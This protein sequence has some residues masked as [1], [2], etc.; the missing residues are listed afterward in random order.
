MSQKILSLLIFTLLCISQYSFADNVIHEAISVVLDDV[1]DAAD[2]ADYERYF[3][4]YAENS[5]FFGTDINERWPLDVFKKYTKARFD[6]GNGWTYKATSRNIFLSNDEQTAW[7][8]EILH[9]EK[10]G[11]SRATGVLVL[12]DGQ[13]KLAQYHLTI[14]IPNELA[15]DFVDQILEFEKKK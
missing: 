4:H 5:V 7:F 10:Y 8:D 9:N 15:Y 11:Y 12:E 13:W 14:P 1:H 3:S 2:A 6:K